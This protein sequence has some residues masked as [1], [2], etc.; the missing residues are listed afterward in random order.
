ME[1][2][3][4]INYVIKLRQKDV[5]LKSA[6]I[7]DGRSEREKR[8]R[9]F[10]HILSACIITS[11]TVLLSH[12]ISPFF[13]IDTNVPIREYDKILVFYCFLIILLA[14]VGMYALSIKVLSWLFNRLNV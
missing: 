9:S 13:G 10:F 14:V 6:K 11:I 2:P 12:I 7:S 3:Q 1:W 4:Q 8:V 5:K